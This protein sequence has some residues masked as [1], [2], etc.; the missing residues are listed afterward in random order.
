MSRPAFTITSDMRAKVKNLAA[1]AM[2]EEQIVK[3]IG[4]SLATLQ[5]RFARELKLGRAEGNAAVA[6]ALFAKARGGDLSA[7]IFWLKTHH[8]VTAARRRKERAARDGGNKAPRFSGHVAIPPGHDES[9]VD[10]LLP[11]M[12][13]AEARYFRKM[14]REEQSGKR[15]P[16]TP[17]T[18]PDY[19]EKT[20]EDE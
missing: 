3:I 7:I 8:W 14:A 16:T 4:C 10:A 19:G 1:L 11:Y 18:F 13:K 15:T 6:G 9:E 5:K 12:G 17:I 2:P 20:G